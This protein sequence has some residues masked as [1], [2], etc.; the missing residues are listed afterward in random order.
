MLRKFRWNRRH[1]WHRRR[2]RHH[3]MMMESYNNIGFV[4]IIGRNGR[5]YWAPRGRE[6]KIH[7]DSTCRACQ[8]PG[9]PIESTKGTHNKKK[10]QTIIWMISSSILCTSSRQSL[11]TSVE[12]FHLLIFINSFSTPCLF[13]LYLK[14]SSCVVDCVFL[15][16]LLQFKNQQLV[17]I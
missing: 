3:Q 16:R 7:W 2:P 13:W 17:R 10:N 9:V 14:S 1:Q 8:S 6:W 4:R 11:Y 15:V 12:V 5:Q